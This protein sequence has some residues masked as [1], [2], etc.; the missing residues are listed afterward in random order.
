MLS[1]HWNISPFSIY[2]QEV[3]WDVLCIKV[4]QFSS[5]TQSCPTLCDHMDCSTP[6]LPVHHQ[7][8]NLLKLMSIKSVMSSNHVILCHPPLLLPSIF[9]S[10]RVFSSESVLCIRWPND[11]SFSFNIS[12]SN[13]YSGLIYFRIDWV[14]ASCSPRDSQ[15]SSPVPQFKNINSSAQLSL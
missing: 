10:N 9:S 5:V 14:W 2:G 12:C 8:Q 4:S 6:G 15:E 11:W 1:S 3:F 13:E 7:L